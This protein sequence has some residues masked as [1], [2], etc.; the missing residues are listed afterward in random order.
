MESLARALQV[1]AAPQG[2]KVKGKV[3]DMQAKQGYS[4]AQIALHWAIAGLVIANYVVSE[5]MGDALDAR[6]EGGTVG[7]GPSAF[8]V[9]AGVAVLVLV[10]ARL[11]LRLTRGAPEAAG[12]GLMGLAARAAHGGLY[13]L[14][15]AVPVLGAITWFGRFDPT[16]EPHALAANLLMGLAALHALAAIFHH[17]VLKDGLIRR[18]MRAG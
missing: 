10:L 18:M 12:E 2:R 4:R 14:M 7:G 6:I 16:G 8:H 13:L 15:L 17:Y 11:G 5:G 3:P 1:D 9:W